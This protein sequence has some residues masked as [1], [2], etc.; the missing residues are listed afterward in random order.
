[1][2]GILWFVIAVLLVIWLAGLV[3]DFLGS[4][5]HIFLVVAIAAIIWNVITSRSRA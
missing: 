1:M 3:L 4:A 5:I 2:A